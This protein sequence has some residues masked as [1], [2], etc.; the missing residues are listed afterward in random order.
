MWSRM[1]V[2]ICLFVPCMFI[3]S[4]TI[5]AD[6]VA[7]AV[8][9]A[10]RNVSSVDSYDFFFT[11]ES[12][13]N[14]HPSSSRHHFRQ[15]AGLI[16]VDLYLD[17]QNSSPG[18]I[19]AFD[20]S[21]FQN[22]DKKESIVSF[23]K[24]NRF[25]NQYGVTNPLT[26][27]FNWVFGPEKLFTW[28]EL[29]L[30]DQWQQAS[31]KCRRLPDN[32]VNGLDCIELEVTWSGSKDTVSLAKKKGFLPVKVVS[33]R[34]PNKMVFTSEVEEIK[35]F[36]VD[37]GICYLPLVYT[38]SFDRGD[39]RGKMRFSIDSKSFRVN[40]QIDDAVF[41]LS[42]SMAKTYDDYD[43]NFGRLAAVLDNEKKAL[44]LD[45]NFLF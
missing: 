27:P 35:E 21:R 23:S 36:P 16:R 9:A 34:G 3:A 30:L 26:T 10:H 4:N 14:G 33:V 12:V 15:S 7:D 13:L 8:L 22:Y 40:H 25:P 19:Y 42:P 29:K 43:L 5:F 39:N 18:S 1:G 45:H 44:D 28:S 6:E 24:S 38:A 41:T 20:G 32:L 31:R 17:G 2:L 37:R 11:D